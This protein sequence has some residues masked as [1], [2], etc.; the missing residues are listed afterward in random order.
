[1]YSKPS[2]QVTH[3]QG[4]KSADS[5]PPPEGNFYPKTRPGLSISAEAFLSKNLMRHL[6]PKRSNFIQIVLM[7]RLKKSQFLSKFWTRS[8]GELFGVLMQ[9]DLV[10]LKTR[11]ST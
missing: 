1:M 11:V 5:N 10:L 9:L 2:D 7:H 3:P 6:G 8:F 4:Y